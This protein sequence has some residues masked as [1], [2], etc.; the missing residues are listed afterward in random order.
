[1]NLKNL[2][3]LVTINGLLAVLTSVPTLAGTDSKTFPGAAC[4]ARSP[5]AEFVRRNSILN[6][7]VNSMAVICPVVRDTF[8]ANTLSSAAI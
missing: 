8:A 6:S 2:A 1:M 5:G 4:Q 7:G 3:R